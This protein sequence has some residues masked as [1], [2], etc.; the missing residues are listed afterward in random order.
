MLLAKSLKAITDLGFCSSKIDPVL[1]GF[2][3]ENLCQRKAT[4][5]YIF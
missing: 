1:Q 5:S 2:K 3:Y 4:F